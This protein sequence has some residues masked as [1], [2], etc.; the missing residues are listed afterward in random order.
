MASGVAWDTWLSP[1]VPLILQQ[2]S[3]GFA[4]G[5]RDSGRE[6]KCTPL[7]P[8][9]CI[10]Q[11]SHETC[12]HSKGRKYFP[13]L[14]TFNEGN[15]QITFQR[16]WVQ[17]RVKCVC[18]FS[19]SISLRLTLGKAV[20][21]ALTMSLFHSVAVSLRIYVLAQ[22]LQEFQHPRSRPA[23]KDSQSDRSLHLSLT[24]RVPTTKPASVARGCSALIG[25]GPVTCFPHCTREGAPV[26][27]ARL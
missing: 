2:A 6:G 21:R 20:F 7:L 1:P 22:W 18:I 12:P 10:G 25:R 26:E 14:N 11:T 27:A 13:F 8:L 9:H 4:A 17:G 3:P 15:Y 16:P 24:D 23:G 5:R 19:Q